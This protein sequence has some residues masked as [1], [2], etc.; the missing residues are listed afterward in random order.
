M[1]QV[2]PPEQVT[3]QELLLT[4]TTLQVEPLWQ[5]TSQFVA[6]AQ[7]KVQVQSFAVQAI[8]G[9]ENV[10]LQ[11]PLHEAHLGAQPVSCTGLSD[12]WSWRG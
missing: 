4:Q 6:P 11:Q 9:P 1:S 3:L 10:S 7:P 8:G 5:S 12:R 2:E